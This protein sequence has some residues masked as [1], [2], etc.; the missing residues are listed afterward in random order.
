MITW[1]IIRVKVLSP[2]YKDHAMHVHVHDST[3]IVWMAVSHCVAGMHIE[4]L[5][6]IC[7]AL[8]SLTS[9]HLPGKGVPEVLKHLLFCLGQAQNN[10]CDIHT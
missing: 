8:H 5:K 6:K 9:L 3:Y 7:I 4:W 10:Y 2:H 1:F